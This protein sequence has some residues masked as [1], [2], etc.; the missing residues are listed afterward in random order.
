MQE[1]TYQLVYMSQAVSLLSIDQL[2]EIDQK[3]NF[4]NPVHGITGLLLYAEGQFLSK[5]Q[6]RFLGIL[7]GSFDEIEKLTRI[8]QKDERHMNLIV[9]YLGQRESRDCP[10]WRLGYLKKENGTLNLNLDSFFDAD[11]LFAE[12]GRQQG[13][14]LSQFEYFKRYGNSMSGS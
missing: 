4:Y 14:Y 10:N 5:L 7:E 13:S 2:Q 11:L 12:I 8:I 3:S 1:E 9:L 6:G